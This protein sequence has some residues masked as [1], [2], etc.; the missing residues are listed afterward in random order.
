MTP[1]E[2]LYGVPPPI[3]IPYFPRD[4]AVESV[5]AYLTTK[6]NLIKRVQ[7]HLQTTQH[8]MT[9]IA[10]RRRSDRSFEVTYYVYLKLQPYRQQSTAA[11][12]SHKLAVKYY[13]L[14]QVLAKVGTVAYKLNLPSSLMIHPVFHVS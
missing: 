6:E 12:V 1:Y 11:R 7:S 13:G 3:H 10:N 9:I 5:D 8:R 2:V 4:S 14:Y